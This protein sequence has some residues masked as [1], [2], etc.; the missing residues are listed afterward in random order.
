[1]SAM[2]MY[3]LLSASAGNHTVLFAT[4]VIEAFAQGVA[5]AA[6]LAY[7]ST[8]CSVEHTA[9]QFALL[10]SVAPLATHT[11]GG[12]SGYLAQATGWT[13]FYVLAMLASL[14]AMLLMLYILH[15]FPPPASEAAP[16]AG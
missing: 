11:V 9:T 3:V 1:M 7:L 6:F 8:L 4:V 16:A 10:T 12:F 15:R 5:T 14:P 13:A 2:A